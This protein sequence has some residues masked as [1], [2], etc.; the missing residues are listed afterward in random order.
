[1]ARRRR[2]L[3]AGAGALLLCALVFAIAL[4][5]QTP[6]LAPTSDAR[7]S[8]SFDAAPVPIRTCSVATEATDPRL[9]T[10]TAMV[11][12]VATGNILFD[13]S[14]ELPV[15]PASVQKVLIAAAALTALGPDARAVTRVV[16]GSQPGELVL[17]GGGDLTLARTGANVYPGVAR[18]SDLAAR[19]RAAFEA[20]TG[21]P[22]IRVTLDATAF[23]GPEWHPSWNT[24]EIGDGYQAPI[25]A[26]MVDGD[27]DDPNALVSARSAD[28]VSRAG[29]AFAAALGV[30]VTVSRGTAPAGA[31]EL[32][33]VESPSVAQLVDIALTYS[34]NVAAEMLARMVAR[35]T[36]AGSTFSAIEPAV[37]T[38]LAGYDLDLTGLRLVDGSGLSDD[39]AVAPALLTELFRHVSAREGN[40]GVLFDALPVAGERGSLR[41]ADR[42]TGENAIARGAVFAKTGWIDDGHTLAG[43]VH[44]ADGTVLSFAI[45]ALDGVDASAK[46]AIDTWV[47]AVYRCGNRLSNQ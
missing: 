2:P 46:T 7:P 1:F 6:V 41:Y 23:G 27:R 29:A 26:L 5:G 25:A 10:M 12:D 39:N 38:A 34:D 21:S 19:A 35:S 13:R 42:F 30:P 45:T 17:V 18:L 44:A 33:S 8:P 28:P 24:K 37:K 43:L 11:R 36:G 20:A 4:P 31:R 15:R 3:A 14:G 9:G 22:P 32:A 16:M 40:L 47:T